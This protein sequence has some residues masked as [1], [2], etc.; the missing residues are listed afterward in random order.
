MSPEP[1]VPKDRTDLRVPPEIRVQPDPRATLETKV[2]LAPLDR[3]VTQGTKGLRAS[4]DQ[5]GLE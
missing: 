5:P 2:R 4:R 3:R 1:K